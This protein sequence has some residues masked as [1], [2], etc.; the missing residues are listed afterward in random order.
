M[1]YWCVYKFTFN[2]SFPATHVTQNIQE[3]LW[4]KFWGLV[5]CTFVIME[6]Y[7]IV[8]AVISYFRYVPEL[9]ACCNCCRRCVGGVKILKTEQAV[10]TRSLVWC[11]ATRASE[12]RDPC[13]S[14]VVASLLVNGAPFSEAA[15][16]VVSVPI[17]NY[18][19]L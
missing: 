6:F 1:Y 19:I 4:T 13:E 18:K 3:I 10:M 7:V 12:K 14:V 16:V 8:C 15:I 5:R 11:Y 9:C 17:R 2:H